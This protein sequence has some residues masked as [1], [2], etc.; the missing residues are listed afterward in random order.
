MRTRAL[1]A[2]AALSLALPLSAL[3][4]DAEQCRTL[5]M[6]ED[7]Q[8][9]VALCEAESER[10]LQTEYPDRILYYCGQARSKLYDE[11]GSVADLTGV[12]E[13]LER[14]LHLYYMPSTSFALGQ[15]RVEALEEV[16]SREEKR[17]L[18]WRG[19]DEMWDAVINR[20][21]EE[22]FSPQVM[23]DT[24]LS[25]ALQYQQSLTELM[26]KEQEDLALVY[27]LTARLRMLSD[28]FVD[29]DPSL[30]EN[31]VRQA[32]LE[33][34]SGWMGD[35]YVATYFDRNP[36]VGMY[37]YLGDRREGEYM[38]D[39]ETQEMFH[40]SLYYY[41]EGLSRAR[42][43]KAKSVLNERIAYLCS[44]Y[45]SEDKDKKLEFYKLGFHNAADGLV[46]MDRIAAKKPEREDR[47]YR[48]EPDNAD[49]TAQLQKHYG[50]NLSGLIY[51]LW[52][53]EDYQAVVALRENAFDIGFDWESKPDDLLRIADAA[54][55]LASQSVGD[56]LMF[57][58]Y[59][60][61]CLTSASRA[62]KFTL[63]KF[64]GRPPSSYD[65]P[66]CTA[67]AAYVGFL[68]RFGETVEAVS[69]ERSYGT[70]CSEAPAA[71]EVSQ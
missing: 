60:E 46:I 43:P 52:E 26:I 32:N 39:D 45:Q 21:A 17:A 51:F 8:G 3:A 66:F 1:L 18:I 33:T 44:L 59:R 29:I 11:N 9:L 28:R 36:V 12:I 38:Q 22:G 42:T 64:N 2:L 69:I 19:T 13:D 23:S 24:L 35:L 14:S 15:A 63:N 48:F 57:D 41:K 58:K 7:Y 71:A 37:K 65:E 62:F 49:L 10:I 54:S 34:I 47:T 67:Q 55:K 5:F 4:I 30:G 31:E 53:R 6:A 68:L 27:W 56:P 61:M 70:V 40:K 50:R 16:S 25:W 20:H